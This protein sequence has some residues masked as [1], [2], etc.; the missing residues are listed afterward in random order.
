M[1]VGR[2]TVQMES[3]VAESRAS[4]VLPFCYI[5]AQGILAAVTIHRTTSQSPWRLLTLGIVIWLA[6]LEFASAVNNRSSGFSNSTITAYSWLYTVQLVNILWIN[7]V[8]SEDF[9]APKV[10]TKG[11]LPHNSFWSV[12]NLVAFNFRGIRTPWKAKNISPFSTYYPG[13]I[14][15]SRIQFLLRQVAILM[16][17]YL[18]IDITIAQFS[19]L[20]P[21]DILRLMG[22]GVEFTYLSAT[23]EQWIFR[24]SS[25]LASRW[26]VGRCF[27]SGLYNFISIVGV[28]TGIFSIENFPPFMGSMW[29]SYTIRGY[30]G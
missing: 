17:Q 7:N 1:S 13:R 2:L 21:E 4:M 12:L 15:Q 11:H 8:S 26:F 30:W 22:P 16:L 27:L 6:Y 29:S 5:L 28:A 3:V 19:K 24:L 23:R 9:K 18:V 14:P 10:H 25:T 20:S